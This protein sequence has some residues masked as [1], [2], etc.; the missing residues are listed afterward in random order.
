MSDLNEALDRARKEFGAAELELR[1]FRVQINEARER[2]IAS[3]KAEI[4]RRYRDLY[5]EKDTALAER[6]RS[7]RSALDAAAIE[8][9]RADTAEYPDG[10]KV[11]RYQWPSYGYGARQWPVGVEL[12]VVEVW[13]KDSARP[14]NMSSYGLPSVGA[15]IVRTI[16][17]SGK[18]G[19]RFATLPGWGDEVWTV[20]DPP[21]KD[22]NGRYP[23]TRGGRS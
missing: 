7:A 9:A 10:A 16:G 19:K 18:P 14:D 2:E 15:K 6:W 17:K 3:A 23:A 8:A 20:G 1:T 22:E 5:G 4:E 21:S 11:W 13:T 12:G